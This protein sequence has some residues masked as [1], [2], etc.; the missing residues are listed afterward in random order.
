MAVVSLMSL[1]AADFL[2]LRLRLQPAVQALWEG[3]SDISAVKLAQMSQNTENVYFG[4]P[5]GL[6]DQLADFALAAPCLYE[7]LKIP[8]NTGRKARPQL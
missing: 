5:C 8:Q 1:V 3:G 4:K 7:L 2:P 6:M